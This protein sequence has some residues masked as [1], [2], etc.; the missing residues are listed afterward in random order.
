MHDTIII[1][2][3][4]A[5]LAAAKALKEKGQDNFLILE[6]RDRVGG[7][8]KPG[9]IA[10]LNI[11]LGG[12]W[13]G[14]SQTRLKAWAEELQVQTYSTPME[15]KGCFRINGKSH[16]GEGENFDG[17]FNLFEGADYLRARR[18]IKKLAEPLDIEAPWDHPQAAEPRRDDRRAMAA[19]KC[20]H[21]TDA[22]FVSDGV[23]L[24]VLC[25]SITNVDALFCA[26]CDVC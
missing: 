19:E 13:L 7:R 3:G 6:A 8:T 26:L 20:P 1:G 4:F 24:P 21:R 10:G 18:K 25:R 9:K 2:A 15:G 11:D 23:F 22:D 5:G 17:L 14:P 12:M 16:Q